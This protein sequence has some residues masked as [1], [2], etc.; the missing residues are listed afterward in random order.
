MH[1]IVSVL[2]RP[3]QEV[4]LEFEVSVGYIVSSRTALAT[5]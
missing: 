2:R 1:P 5:V 4:C 3:R